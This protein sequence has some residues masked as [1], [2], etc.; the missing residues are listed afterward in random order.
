M[1]P[2][3]IV[4]RLI[5]L[6]VMF[7]PALGVTGAPVATTSSAPAAPDETEI[8]KRLA[9]TY[10]KAGQADKAVAEYVR[11]ADLCSQA[12]N[13]ALAA[14]ALQRATEL[15]PGDAKL[16][17]RLATAYFHLKQYLGTVVQRRVPDGTPGRIAGEYYL[18]EPVPNRPETWFA[19]PSSSALYQAQRA[20][21]AGLDDVSA[22]LLLADIWLEVGR[23]ETALAIYRSIEKRVPPTEQAVYYFRS[24]QAALGVDA[25]DEYLAR[26]GRAVELDPRKYASTLA[27][28]HATVAQR[29]SRRGDLEGFI[30]HLELAAKAAPDSPDL[31]YRLG[32]AYWEA[33]RRQEAARHWQIALELQPDHPDRE[34]ILGRLRDAAPHKD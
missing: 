14:Q 4:R 7:T 15:T 23:Y 27:D 18:L 8:H 17:L 31:H 19:C 1:R 11:V 5:T 26:L 3:P 22:Q 34:R 25:L 16:R 29:C 28:A 20:L 32:N 30:R 33:N 21:D 9:E 13:H 2:G 12:G 24:A 6:S 10:D